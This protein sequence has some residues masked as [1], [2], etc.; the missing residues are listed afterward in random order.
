LKFLPAALLA[1]FL[2]HA[3]DP[4]HE[5]LLRWRARREASLKA[6]GGWLSVAGLFWLHQGANPFGTAADNAIVLPPGS[7]PAHA[8]V[9][10]LHG[11]NLI[12]VMDGQRR[13]L[14]W[15]TSD[16]VQAGTVRLSPILR[17][18]RYGIRMK[19]PNSAARRRFHGLRWY[20]PK[21]AWRITARFVTAPR[22][23][24]IVN[25]LGQTEQQDSP[26][27]AEFTAGGRRLRLYPV[28]EPDSRELFFIFRDQT[29]GK[30]TY[31][32][33]RFLD[34]PMPSNG[35]VVLDF[36]KAYNPPCV[37]TPFATCPLPP[38]E[39]RLPV[40]VEAGEMT[41]GGH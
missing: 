39:N 4:Y 16:A 18:D 23:L 26:G 15:D 40:A 19:D 9:F 38:R 22:K 37:F 11:A 7:G 24:P 6:E 31:G 13:P 17:G 35:K 3:A 27:Y 21:P 29:S 28:L 12:A 32:A 41:Y 14:R 36:N 20:P 5:E 1:V 30:Q 33:G 8:G 2:I 25:V 10:E 34:T